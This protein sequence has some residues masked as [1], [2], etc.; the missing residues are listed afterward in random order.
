MTLEQR[1]SLSFISKE[2]G[3][4]IRFHELL[5][6]KLLAS[7]SDIDYQTFQEILAKYNI[8]LTK[9]DLKG[10]LNTLS[11][12]FYLPSDRKKYGEITYVDFNE[13][14]QTF[15]RTSQFNDLLTSSD[16]KYGLLDYLEQGIKQAI[17]KPGEIMENNNLILY[18]KYYR[19]DICK[20]LNWECD[21]SNTIFGYRIKTS[22]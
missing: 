4:G 16:Y 13:N 14:T 15:Y 2:F 9:E 1:R 7:K 20:L 8:K 5:I 17:L 3:R 11:P 12:D 6:L 21:C 18:R 19:K 10:V 22:K